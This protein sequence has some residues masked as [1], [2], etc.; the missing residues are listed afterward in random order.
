[1]ELVDF[2]LTRRALE[3]I[4]RASWKKW[5]RRTGVTGALGSI[6]YVVR[7]KR[8]NCTELVRMRD[9]EGEPAGEAI[10]SG[11][12]A[13]VQAALAGMEGLRQ[14]LQRRLDELNDKPSEDLKAVGLDALQRDL[15]RSIQG[16]LTEEGKLKDVLHIQR[17]GSGSDYDKLRAA[18]RSRLDSL[19]V[20]LSTG[21][22]PD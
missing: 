21:K 4:L 11:V 13:R 22:V 18:I 20:S 15:A 8:S 14:V 17:G 16:V 12:E 7:T 9:D 10:A 3:N 1:M 5:A 6:S 19:R 2:V